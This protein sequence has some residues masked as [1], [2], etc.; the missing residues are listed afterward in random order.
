MDTAHTQVTA[1]VKDLGPLTKVEARINCFAAQGNTQAETAAEL[2]RSIETIKTHS[3]SILRKLGA[4][5]TQH[6]I[7]ISIA[8]GLVEV[9]TPRLLFLIALILMGT[10]NTS[11]D[12][13][14]FTRTRTSGT[15]TVR[16][17]GR[18]YA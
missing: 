16:R 14:K 4:K 10:I 2:H 18:R 6:A 17:I 11:E 3:K 5:S 8:T 13:D 7:A 1:E 12:K 15:R 9:R